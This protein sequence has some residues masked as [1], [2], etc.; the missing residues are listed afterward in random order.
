[1]NLLGG[2]QLD[3]FRRV[4]RLGMLAG[5]LLFIGTGCLEIREEIKLTGKNR[6]TF[7]LELSV[8]EDVYQN[9]LA[10]AVAPPEIARFF[11]PSSGTAA[12][13]AAK[14]F[15]VERYRVYEQDGRRG[16]WMKGRLV[17]VRQAFSSGLLGTFRQE[18]KPDGTH[19][20]FL[21]T[22]DWPKKGPALT[23]E[24]LAALKDLRLA[25]TV[26]VPG[27]ILRT[28]GKIVRSHRVEWV[29]AVKKDTL[30]F[31]RPP[32]VYIEYR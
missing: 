29:F 25:F 14:G 19:R 22:Q 2:I 15:E 16:L 21:D 5:L 32:E 9:F 20:F 7:Q 18:E 26:T 10:P 1:M 11:S 27:K 13:S 31:R 17:N 3:Q 6:G 12:Y 30:F 8:P 24:E 23:A 4:L 28:S